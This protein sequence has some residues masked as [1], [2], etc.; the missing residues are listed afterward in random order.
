MNC[1]LVRS[2]SL[3]GVAR[4]VCSV[5]FTGKGATK[6]TDSVA[7]AEDGGSME[8]R[9]DS[10]SGALVGTL[11]VKPT[12]DLNKWESHS[13]DVTGAKGVHNLFLRFTGGNGVQLNFDG[14]MFN[15]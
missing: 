12:G 7:S 11:K 5:D 14:W 15:K 1:V 9:L 4:G 8:L 3:M 10:G 13:C 2:C 6:F